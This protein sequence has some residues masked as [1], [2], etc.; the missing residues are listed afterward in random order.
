MTSMLPEDAGFSLR[1]DITQFLDSLFHQYL[2]LMV[3][4]LD[5]RILA[6][7]AILGVYEMCPARRVKTDGGAKDTAKIKVL[8]DHGRFAL[9]V[10]RLRHLRILS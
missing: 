8:G 10:K 1:A 3:A 2:D 6:D 7:H 9:L 5:A 4:H